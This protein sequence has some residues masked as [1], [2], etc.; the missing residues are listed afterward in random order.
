MDWSGGIIGEPGLQAGQKIR[1]T[2]G[3]KTGG[4]PGFQVQ[5]F[6]ESSFVFKVYVDALGN[7]EYLT[8]AVNPAVKIVAE[9]PNKLTALMPSNTIVG[10]PTW[11]VVQ[12]EDRFGNPATRYSGTISFK[13]TDTLAMVPDRYTFTKADKGIHRFE[14]IVFNTRGYQT[15]SVEDILPTMLLILCSFQDF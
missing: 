14:N 2:Y 3:D 7:K 11:C 12:A 5:P 15:V 4:S 8:L 1:V 10:K 6:D 13:T 9:R